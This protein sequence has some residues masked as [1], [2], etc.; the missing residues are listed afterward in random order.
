MPVQIANA[1]VLTFD[2]DVKSGSGMSTTM[3]CAIEPVLDSV[4]SG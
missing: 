1:L 3:V 2:S 4:I